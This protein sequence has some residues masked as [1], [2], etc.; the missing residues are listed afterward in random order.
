[1][2]TRTKLTKEE[3]KYFKLFKQF[4]KINGAFYAF[5]KNY[6]QNQNRDYNFIKHSIYNWIAVSFSWRDTNQGYD[7]WYSLQQK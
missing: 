5:T 7:Y 3:Q 1:M 6:Q 2:E 4:L